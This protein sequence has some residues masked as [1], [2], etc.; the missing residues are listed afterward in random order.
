VLSGGNQQKI[1][2]GRAVSRAVRSTAFV[3]AQPTRGVDV[4]AARD[5]HDEIRGVAA[6]GKA[7]VVLSADLGELRALA[8]R[9]LVLSRG[10][11]VAEFPPDTPEMRLGEAM[12]GGPEEVVR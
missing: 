11:I 5:I 4:G 12:L 8:D 7:V 9:I 3:F 2:V 1:V 10:R 6:A